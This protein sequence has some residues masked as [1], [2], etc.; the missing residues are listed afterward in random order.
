MT[1][2]KDSYTYTIKW[3]HFLQQKMILTGAQPNDFIFDRRK[4][5]LHVHNQTTSFLTEEKDSYTCTI[6]R[7]HFWQK[8]RILTRAQSNDFIFDRRN[9]RTSK[10]LHLWQ[11]KR[12]LTRAQSNDFIFESRKGFLHVHSLTTSFFDS[13]KGFLHVHNQR[14]SFFTAEKDNNTRTIKHL[15]QQKRILTS[16]QSNDFIFECRKGF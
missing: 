8:K 9:R 4:G 16:A 13:R 2:E 7:L 3:L 12:I 10:R 6:T 11:Q 1:A 14:T 15:W 5:F